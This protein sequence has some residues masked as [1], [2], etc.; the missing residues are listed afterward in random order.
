MHSRAPG[1]GLLAVMILELFAP[2]AFAQAS[3]TAT[4]TP[5][6]VP[7]A[8]PAA[9]LIAPTPYE[10]GPVSSSCEVSDFNSNSMKSTTQSNN[11]TKNFWDATLGMQVNG[12]NE[13]S[14]LALQ[15]GAPNATKQEQPEQFFTVDEIAGVLGK[16]PAEIR[17]ALDI[18]VN[19]TNQTLTSTQLKAVASMK[20][21][22]LIEQFL[23]IKQVAPLQKEEYLMVQMPNG[24]KVRMSDV[25]NALGYGDQMSESC[26]LDHAAITGEVSFMA[27]LNRDLRIGDKSNSEVLR[28]KNI[29][30]LA[31]VGQ[32]LTSENTAL[33][34][35]YGS[36]GGTF[37][38][39]K[40]YE[41]FIRETGQWNLVDMAATATLAVAA[42]TSKTTL[43]KELETSKTKYENGAKSFAEI[44]NAATAEKNAATAEKNLAAHEANIAKVRAEDPKGYGQA[45]SRAVA[46]KADINN[47]L[48]QAALADIARTQELRTAA[49]AE[50]QAF[51]A[52]TEELGKL[53]NEMV[54]VP[55]AEM[56]SAETA[57][58]AMDKVVQSAWNAPMRSIWIGA[59][60]LLPAR[61]ALHLSTKAI[62][63]Q[64][65]NDA[66]IDIYANK[67]EMLR[68]FRDVTSFFGLAKLADMITGALGAEILPEK[69]FNL[70]SVVIMD[71]PW[72]EESVGTV[73]G[74]VTSIQGSNIMLQWQGDSE[75]AFFEDLRQVRDATSLGV[76]SN[77]M[78]FGAGVPYKDQAF[79]AYFTG[80]MAT[81]PVA[82]LGIKLFKAP[83]V[84][85]G[86]ARAALFLVATDMYARLVTPSDFNTPCDEGKVN[87][88]LTQFKVAVS[89]DIAQSV[90][91]Y[92]FGTNIAGSALRTA[93]TAQALRAAKV[94]EGT[95]ESEKQASYFA[96]F[97]EKFKTMGNTPA[98]RMSGFSQAFALLDPVGIY[99]F[100]VLSSGQEYVTSCQEK[101]YYILSYQKIP[102][103]P[104][105][106]SAQKAIQNALKPISDA[107]G[108]L[109][110]ANLTAGAA[111]QRVSEAD[112]QEMLNMRAAMRDQYGLLRPDQ[113][114][115]L[116]MFNAKLSWWGAFTKACQRTVME[117]DKAALIADQTGVSV[118]DKAT[119]A[120][121]PIA[122]SLR[123][124]LALLSQEL[125]RTVIPNKIISVDMDSPELAFTVTRDQKLYA[126]NMPI[127]NCIKQRLGQ[128]TGMNITSNDL[129]SV[130][131]KVQSIYTSSGNVGWTGSTIRWT[132]TKG[133]AG[134]S[135]TLGMGGTEAVPAGVEKLLESDSS[136]I[137]IYGNAKVQ[138]KDSETIDGGQL[139]TV[140]TENGRMEYDPGTGK[141]YVVLYVMASVSGDAIKGAY[142]KPGTVYDPDCNKEAPAINF[143]K[144]VAQPGAE[145]EVAKLQAALA[146][147]QKDSKGNP[148]GMQV[149]ETKDHI[150]Y[151]TFDALC[152]PILRIYDKATGQWTDYKITGPLTTDEKGNIVVPTDK[153]TFKFGLTSQNGVPMLQVSG[154]GLEELLPLLAARGEGGS[155]VFDPYNKRWMVFNGQ[156]VPW[157]PDFMNKGLAFQGTSSGLQGLPGEDVLRQPRTTTGAEEGGINPL[158]ALPWAPTDSLGLLVFGAILI[159]GVIGIRRRLDAE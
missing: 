51:A 65:R 77:S 83:G 147:V 105:G 11:P 73:K 154:P 111:G 23:G 53:Q 97:A 101:E 132:D 144:V 1:I 142:I 153:G 57:I 92:A 75:A 46:G 155:F 159:L 37:V 84:G 123:S 55:K 128:I 121:T 5:T 39:G 28:D 100:T 19:A 27:L 50:S 124:L 63:E 91:L 135:G 79:D 104:S 106:T 143:A 88:F 22:G 94:A 38:I 126:E 110:T 80:L 122:D 31:S 87:D 136:R 7:T 35:N 15:F 157:N 114:F 99:M 150:Y 115:Y 113:I 131:G 24:K 16:D 116:H 152:N 138:L 52:S 149:L 13:K 17:S 108:G 40:L 30:D 107:L 156:D 59:G 6:A 82:Y 36:S 90:L 66:Y 81:A 148:G 93:Q 70:G 68:E 78:D 48:D 120:L 118:F 64:K 133:K 109:S 47:P 58:K 34:I 43:T 61:L 139:L 18:P 32:H 12:I 33:S 140:L 41:K 45:Y 98:T 21:G 54:A 20:P 25:V 89:I 119:G 49:E 44:K 85:V 8:T 141:L 102:S 60:W 145:E 134:T 86:I 2:M 76:Y 151:F 158:L 14:N 10:A 67:R 26:T 103:G 95:I 127:A 72:P 146:Q 3:P 69:T 62:L 125:G 9:P 74:S 96:R 56:E 112:L 117:G 129:T 130:M 29:Q 4:A 42:S 71:R 137:E